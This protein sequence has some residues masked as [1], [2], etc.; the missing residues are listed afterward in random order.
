[1]ALPVDAGT[2]GA[3][4]QGRLREVATTRAAELRSASSEAIA[5]CLESASRTRARGRQ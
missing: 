2:A 3:G 1:M 4:L 5:Q